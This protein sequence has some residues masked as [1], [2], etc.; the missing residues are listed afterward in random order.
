MA[1]WIEIDRSLAAKPQTWEI[2]KQR[3]VNVKEVVDN[4]IP[5]SQA[6]IARYPKL[7]NNGEALSQLLANLNYYV[8]LLG[9]LHAVTEQL[10]I[11]TDKRYEIEKGL[12]TVR[13][14]KEEKK[15]VNYAQNAKYVKVQDYLD[16]MVRS[17]ALDKRVQNARSSA[18]DTTE[19]IRSRIGQLRGQLRSS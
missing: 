7:N 11:W 8:Q 6:D 2:I 10:K 13:L 18:R 5:L 12:E 19:A 1:N 3:F 4:T 16:I 9:E 15:A 14:V 17:A